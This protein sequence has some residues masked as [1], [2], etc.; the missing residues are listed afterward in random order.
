MDTSFRPVA[1]RPRLRLALCRAALALLACPAFSQSIVVNS[2]AASQI[3]S[4]TSFVFSCSLSSLPNTGSVEWLVNGESIG[5]VWSQPWSLTWNT[6]ELFNSPSAWHS[7]RVIARD[8]LGNVLATSAPVS[9]GVYNSYLEPSSYISCG[10]ITTSSALNANWSG[11]VTITV[12][13][14]GSNASNH[15]RLYAMVDGDYRV[16][17]VQDQTLTNWVIPLNT[18][19]FL[20]GPHLVY[21]SARDEDGSAH[22]AG[23]YPFC[24]WEQTINFQNG[25]RTPMELLV[26]PKE[27]VI[28]PGAT[29]QLSPIIDN[30]NGTT[31][32]VSSP[33]YSSGNTTVCTV[34]SSG[35][36]TGVAFGT[37]P[38]TVTSGGFMRTIYGYVSTSNVVPHFGSDGVLHNTYVPGVS[39]W[40]ADIFQITANTSFADRTKL[41]SSYGVPYTQAGFNV[42]EGPLTSGASLWGTSQSNFQS[43]LASFIAS[44]TAPLATYNLFYHGITTPLVLGCV[45]NNCG[46][47][48]SSFYSGTRG[49]GAT[50]SPPAWTYLAQ[51]WMNTG[52]LLGISG[53]DEADANYPYP[54][55]SGAL[56]SAGG[57]SGITCSAAAPVVCT[58]A[59]SSPGPDY[60]GGLAFII[61]GATTNSVLNN[62]IGG[63]IYAMSNI[64]AGSGFQFQA[65]SGASGITVTTSS[66]PSLIVECFAYEWEE[67]QTDYVHYGDWQTVFNNIRAASPAPPITGPVRGLASAGSQ[68]GWM[69]NPSSSDYAEIYATADNVAQAHPQ[70]ALVSNF[71]GTQGI[72]LGYNVRV[73]WSNMRAARAFLTISNGTTLN[74]GL[75]GAALSICSMAGPLVTFCSPHGISTVY[76]SIS[77]L[78]I[79]GSANPYFNANAYIDAC[80]TATTCEISLATP[81]SVPANT[82]NP[83]TITF[84]DGSTFTNVGM[85]ASGGSAFCFGGGTCNAPSMNLHNNQ[86]FTWSGSG[87]SAYYTSNTFR[88]FSSPIAGLVNQAQL[89]WREVP[90][91]SQTSSAA[92]A[93]VLVSNNFVKGVNHDASETRTGQRYPFASILFSAVLGSAGHRFYQ[94]GADYTIGAVLGNGLNTF[95]DTSNFTIQ[96]GVSP[97]YDNGETHTV[98]SFWAAASA[99]LMLE[100]LA[101]RGYLFQP[102]YGAPDIG[103]NIETTL[104]KGS[105]GNLLLTL[106]LQD[107]PQT[108]TV[109]LS[110]CVVSNQ[111]TIRYTVD[112]RGIDITT[113]AAGVATDSP[114]WAE[115]GAVAYL[116]ANNS[117]AEY[118]QPVVS[119][120][121]ADVSGAAKIVVQ[122][123]YVPYML[124]RRTNN[125]IDC[126]TGTCA[127]PVDRNIGPVYYRLK[128]LD[129]NGTLLATSDVQSF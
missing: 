51:Q 114:V 78:T 107:G 41:Q 99:N 82:P 37:C 24:G 46:T 19:R 14:T 104:R 76:T 5:I 35:L 126:G 13:I 70:Y 77:R 17:N 22:V 113:I 69:G 105:S 127:L 100:R 93:V 10:T 57:P 27:W 62:T 59:W 102:R 90:A 108:R 33:A 49:I 73:F 68:Y 30:T 36:V 11:T 120:S 112:W 80:P 54:L 48:S 81:S 119:A 106:N 86:T 15:K 124:A 29:Q 6:N 56:G 23:G 8:S 109:D 58:V 42:Y 115:G 53:P 111:P 43:T 20:N 26:N 97:L 84:Q 75:E 118:N 65:P 25:S 1:R 31:G 38:V 28:A 47:G 129:A 40:F 103:Y 85:S 123:A 18:S 60:S 128:Y 125:V 64:V 121:L 92:S 45:G 74:Y 7:V 101:S 66:D 83:G 89:F 110:G 71:R 72:E 32:T 16:F 98:D 3:L 44:A 88:L 122:F 52:R 50:Y 116:C 61:T 9:F 96:P 2:P 94:A 79:S 95:G 91:G 39:L 87:A 4:G 63:S 12:P 67:N 34:S 21:L 117:A 55:A